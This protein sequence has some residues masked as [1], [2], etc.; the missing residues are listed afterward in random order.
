M[1]LLAQGATV[2]SVLEHLRTKRLPSAIA[3]YF[4]CSPNLDFNFRTL[5]SAGGYYDQRY[6]D[7][8][9]FAIIENQLRDIMRRRGDY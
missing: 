4:W 2:T 5:P 6:R 9:E 8:V 3:R 7:M 1:E